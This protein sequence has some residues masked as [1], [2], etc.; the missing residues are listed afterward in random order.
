MFPPMT[1]LPPTPT[2]VTARA[3]FALAV[4][5]VGLVILGLVPGVAT[6]PWMPLPSFG[7]GLRAA[8]GLLVVAVLIDRTMDLLVLWPY[9]RAG[10]AAR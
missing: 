7:G 4:V 10:R 3:A 6:L 5:T 1:S 2:P 8:T 9:W